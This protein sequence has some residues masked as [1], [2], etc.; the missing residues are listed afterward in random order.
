MNL[1]MNDVRLHLTTWFNWWLGGWQDAWAMLPKPAA[2][3]TRPAIFQTTD[4]ARLS[5]SATVNTP[6]TW[7][8]MHQ[9]STSNSAPQGVL[10]ADD[11]VLL[12]E[13]NLPPLS[14]RDI[15]AAVALDAQIAS[16]FPASDTH[17]GYSIRRLTNGQRQIE[18]ALIRKSKLEQLQIQ[19]PQHALFARGERGAIPLQN[20][21]HDRQTA[22]YLSP[23][24][25]G[26]S[27]LLGLVL[28]AWI[29]SPTLLLRAESIAHE[30]AFAKLNRAAAPLLQKREELSALQQQLESARAFDNEHP[31]PQ[32]I[33]E[34]L[35][36]HIPDSTWISQLTLRK[37]QLT[38]EGSSDNAIAI[39]SL[40]EKIPALKEVRL[41]ASINRDPRNGRETFQILARIQASTPSSTLAKSTQAN[42]AKP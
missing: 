39:V 28:I 34:Q 1:S 31:A 36:S 11:D 16:P 41:G 2:L 42:G 9:A 8:S 5:F 14:E 38:L 25:L 4:G 3:Q 35:S 27:I 29:I 13:L 24:T 19:Y 10:L 20:D 32:P 12:R 37:D 23:L 7:L 18:I 21:N 22:W 6:G 40:L 26:L 17:F 33:L 15:A 30:A